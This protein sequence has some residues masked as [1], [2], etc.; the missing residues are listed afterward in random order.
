[1]RKMD[2]YDIVV[3]GAGPGGYVAAIRAA[4]EGATVALIE[5]EAIGGLCLNWGCIPSKILLKKSGTIS[6]MRHMQEMG[7]V[8]GNWEVNFQALV[9][10]S[11]EKVEAIRMGLEGLIASSKVTIIPG[12]ASF[13][14]NDTI[15]LEDHSGKITVIRFGKG[16]IIATGGHPKTLEDLNIKG[17]VDGKH[18]I[19]S[20][21]ALALES[22]PQSIAIIGGGVIGCEMASFF[23]A[24]KTQVTIIEYQPQ[25]LSGSDPDV[26]KVLAQSY[27]N[28]G[29][30]LLTSNA[31]ERTEIRNDIVEIFLKD[32]EEPV[33]AEK[34]LVALGIKAGTTTLGL[35]N[36][37]VEPDPRWGFIPVDPHSYQTS[38]PGIYAIG[39]VITLN[40]LSIP[41][42]GLAHVAS[43]E[44]ELA[45]EHILHKKTSWTIDYNNI[46]FAIFTDPE[47]GTVGL[48]EEKAK[49]LYPDH[50]DHIVSQTVRD[51]QMG[52]GIAL[53]EAEL[54]KLV[55]DQAAYGKILGAHIIGPAATERIHTIA[56]ARRSEDSAIFMPRMLYA[57]PTFSEF[58]REAL[59]ALDGR[60]VHVPPRM[61][62]GKKKRQAS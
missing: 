57:H 3:I 23:A 29:V 53:Q 36:I 5:K 25:I 27:K 12:T 20:R 19:T 40:D 22:L 35:E 10:H 62:T 47:I 37:G 49:E 32:R 60:A 55:V 31:V 39:D 17:E 51:G 26:S 61:Q 38:V 11:R 7:I 33:Q 59:L 14:S 28:A 46:P 6:R 30:T 1:M 43:A 8:E 48:T 21:E 56:E 24:L 18:I 50:K 2:T 16:A 15:S 58:I 45:V 34:V 13:E 52:I 9:A 4:Q 44:G 41:H 42:P 54:T